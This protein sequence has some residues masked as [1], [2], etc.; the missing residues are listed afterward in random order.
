MAGIADNLKQTVN[1]WLP[2]II[3]YRNAINVGRTYLSMMNWIKYNDPHLFQFVHLEINSHCN[4]QCWYCLQSRKPTDEH[5]MAQ[6]VFD[7]AMERLQELDWSAPIV[8]HLL[9]EPLLHP[10]IIEIVAATRKALPHSLPHVTTNGDLLTVDIADKLVEAGLVRCLITQH[11]PTTEQWQTKIDNICSRHPNIFQYMAI[12]R[13][14]M[15]NIGG[16]VPVDNPKLP[17]CNAPK[18]SLIIRHTGQFGLCCCTASFEDQYIF[19]N[20]ADGPILEQW[21]APRWKELRK[22]LRHGE[23]S[24]PICRDCTGIR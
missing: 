11:P 13:E 23:R 6:N 10:Q 17:Y 5:Y 15:L 1:R 2:K 22:S 12:Q 7:L 18:R 16:Q 20:I 19:G 8:F 9:N 24:L 21:N 4:R 3:G 14:E